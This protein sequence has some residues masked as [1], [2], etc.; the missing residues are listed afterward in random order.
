MQAETQNLTLARKLLPHLTLESLGK[1]LP[2]DLKKDAILFQQN[3]NPTNDGIQFADRLIN[4]TKGVTQKPLI[5]SGQ[6]GYGLSSLGWQILSRLEERGDSALMIPVSD[7]VM[8][9]AHE[10]PFGERSL[11]YITPAQLK[12]A[13]RILKDNST[14]AA[15]LASHLTIVIDDVEQSGYDPRNLNMGSAIP[16]LIT[17]RD[18]G[19][20][21]V[22]LNRHLQSQSQNLAAG[23]ILHWCKLLNPSL[24][25]GD[26]ST[27]L[28]RLV[29]SPVQNTESRFIASASD[30]PRSKWDNA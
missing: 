1:P 11:P 22:I 29:Y 28:L 8:G 12:G 17:L 20:N 5:V 16:A 26:N 4:W 24:E 15:K 2:D 13:A 3:E 21:F 27:K 7:L 10:R 23:N 14:E 18:L 6:Q 25:Y 19:A 30:I 9:N